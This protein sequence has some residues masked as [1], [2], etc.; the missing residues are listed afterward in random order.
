MA[1]P[2]TSKQ[3]SARIDWGYFNR[4]GKVVTVRGWLWHAAAA[5]TAVPLAYA[6]ATVFAT[7]GPPEPLAVAASRG[8]LAN[9]HASLDNQCDACHTPYRP[10]SGDPWVSNVLG[11]VAEQKCVTCHHGPKH[12]PNL[13]DEAVLGCVVCHKDHQGRDFSMVRVDDA[14]CA[15]CHTDLPAYHTSPS[16]RS[17]AAIRGFGPGEGHPEIKA[18]TAAPP[19]KR[20]LKFSHATHLTAGLNNS[21]TFARIADPADRERYKVL[22]GAAENSAAVQLDCASCHQLDAG[23]TTP[24]N[25]DLTPAER[26]AAL[27]GDALGGLPREPLLPPRTGG[28]TYL[29]V[30][31]EAH[32]RACHP[33]TFDDAPPLHTVQAPHRATSADLDRFLRQVYAGR[34]VTD[35]LFRPGRAAVAGGTILARPGE[36][37]RGPG[38]VDPRADG[39]DD[40]PS[41]EMSR[42]GAAIAR[43]VEDGAAVALRLLAPTCGKCHESE[44]GKVAPTGTPTVWMPAARFDHTAHRAYRCDSCHQASRDGEKER[45]RLVGGKAYQHPPDLPKLESCQVC[46]GPIRSGGQGGVRAGCTDCHS[47]HQVDRGLQGPGAP[48]RAPVHPPK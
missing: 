48:G 17:F 7:G 27:T 24:A 43:Q 21:F 5:V 46:H 47:Y 6:A 23:R 25:V 45:G 2:R 34:F 35:A 14:T 20:G 44:A 29:P 38:R 36:P 10:I 22:L 19:P 28:Q 9:P 8:P 18:L 26:F 3:K 16:G 33:L 11:G 39:P 13:K 31:F 41:P 12:H 32:C 15:R 4:R 37:A 42:V 40:A 30:N 1:L